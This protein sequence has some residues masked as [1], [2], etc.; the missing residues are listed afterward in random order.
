[1]GRTKTYVSATISN[2]NTDQEE[3]R[4]A[5]LNVLNSSMNNLKHFAYEA[6]T[7]QRGNVGV[8]MRNYI[9]W[10]NFYKFKG[11]NCE[12]F[13][14]EER[15]YNE[16]IGMTSFK[17]SSSPQVDD[18][19]VADILN[20]DMEPEEIQGQVL[21]LPAVTSS[22]SFID[23][24]IVSDV[25]RTPV[26]KLCVS[27][28]GNLDISKAGDTYVW[29][30]GDKY[31]DRYLKYQIVTGKRSYIAAPGNSAADTD[32]VPLPGK[33][34][35][36]WLLWGYDVKEVH[37]DGG[38]KVEE[39]V[40]NE[41]EKEY[42]ELNT[43]LADKIPGYTSDTSVYILA[44]YVSYENQ[45]DAYELSDG[46][47]KLDS[48]N[49][50]VPVSGS[51]M[52]A[53]YAYS[54]N[55]ESHDNIW[56]EEFLSPVDINEIKFFSLVLSNEDALKDPILGPTTSQLH[57]DKD[58]MFAPPIGFMFDKQWIP[59]DNYMYKVFEK[60][61]K[62]YSSDKSYYSEMRKSVMDSLKGAQDVAYSY[63]FFGLPVNMCQTAY[64]ARY[65]LQ[66][67]KMLTVPDWHKWVPG[68]TTQHVSGYR[69]WAYHTNPDLINFNLDWSVDA[70]DYRC[71][72]GICP[73]PGW[74][75]VRSGE[76][77][78]CMF[79]NTPTVWS[80][81]GTDTWEL[82]KLARYVTGFPFIKNGIGTGVGAEGW[83]E[84]I[85]ETQDV[86]RH[87]A[88]AVI[89][90]SK[91]VFAHI[92]IAD[93]TDCIQYTQHV[94]VAAYKIVKKKWY[95]TGLFKVILAVIAIA[96]TVIISIYCPPAGAATG[97]TIGTVANAAFKVIIT[98]AL[99]YAIGFVLNSVL[100]PILENLLGPM[101]AT[102]ITQVATISI[103]VYLASNF[104]TSA[105]LEE[106]TRPQ[107][108]LALTEAGVQGYTKVIYN[109]LQD[110][111]ANMQE[112]LAQIQGQIQDVENATATYLEGNQQNL[113]TQLN[114][115]WDLPF[116][117]LTDNCVCEGGESFMTRIF[118][119][120]SDIA[121]NCISSV[122]MF[123]DTLTSQE[124]TL[125]ILA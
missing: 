107:S 82:I 67:F 76:A 41:E 35:D 48:N 99:S 54:F 125:G 84:P 1:M 119:S 74:S 18:T 36:M 24:N 113:L 11:Y 15:T 58:I 91:E 47:I 21:T 109:R 61:G 94:G 37:E 115:R 86:K 2:L 45:M 122:E 98:M 95:Q 60:A 12:P 78:V 71:G 64:G 51:K 108:W 102:I 22:G 75:T 16:I 13:L 77:G 112:T 30:N 29:S 120:G 103:S 97:I 53:K 69:R 3:W 43:W 81:T 116:G 10:A 8:S 73:A 39:N 110:T 90:V 9:R 59:E 28:T 17:V 5:Q 106:F 20:L 65:A 42:V 104:N 93:F 14:N 66:F 57:I 56:T 114:S 27:H 38:N 85:W 89:P 46:R 87:Y 25:V 63:I 49:M 50:P 83:F 40:F 92:P 23:I 52:T 31:K 32:G 72:T 111:V 33:A 117:A 96:V 80:Q 62:K 44:G 118:L 105:I 26:L 6:M 68:T 124:N 88:K 34:E 101:L 100:Y 4:Y 55:F 70:A 121:D 19:V 123:A 79:E 7:D